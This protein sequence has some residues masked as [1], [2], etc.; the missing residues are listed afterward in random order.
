MAN[1]LQ[2]LVLK[3][4]GDS[5]GGQ[6]AVRDLANALSNN[7][8]KALQ[9][10]GSKTE[11]SS[12]KLSGFKKYLDDLKPSADNAGASFQSLHGT[13][14]EMWENPTAA[15]KGLAGAVGTDLSASLGVAGVAAGAALGVFTVLAAAA[16]EFA[17]R[18]AKVGANLNDMSEKTEIAV[19]VL[20]RWSN[21]A[22]V[23]GTDINTLANG[24][25]MMQ[26]QM[27]ESPDKFEKGLERINIDFEEFKRLSP[28][29]QLLAIA[30]GLRAFPLERT[31]AGVETLGRFAKDNIPSLLKMNEAMEM[32]KDLNP[33]TAEEAEQAEQFEMHLA[34]IKAH[35]EE[36]GT[37]LG[38]DV[39][40]SVDRFLGALEV[41]SHW[42]P[43]DWMKRL[44]LQASNPGGFAALSIPL[45]RSEAP[46]D[47]ALPKEGNGQVVGNTVEQT[48]KL[49][50]GAMKDRAKTAAEYAQALRNVMLAE[51]G[52]Q[53]ALSDLDGKVVEAIRFDLEHKAGIE[54][55]ARVYGV[56]RE[57]VKLVQ[58]Q[59]KAE[60]E[61]AK[62]AA[63]E[64]K[65][66]ADEHKKLLEQIRKIEH[67][68]NAASVTEL[69]KIGKVK[70]VVSKED[71]ANLEDELRFR[72]QYNDEIAQLVLTSTQFQIYQVEQ[73]VNDEKE[74]LK[75]RGGNWQAAYDEIE[76]IAKLHIQR[77]NA[78]VPTIGKAFADTLDGLPALIQQAFTGGGGLEGAMKAGVVLL[79][80]NLFGKDGVWAQTVTP[81]I[82]ARNA[83]ISAAILSGLAV[84]SGLVDPNSREGGALSGAMMGASAGAAIAPYLGPYG[85][86]AVGIGAGAGAIA[87]ALKV[88]ADEK[89]ARDQFN[90][91]K[92][93]LDD[94]FESVAT[95]Q[96]RI[97]AGG[98][99]WA[100]MVIAVR[101]AYVATGRTAAQAMF[102]LETATRH[103]RDDVE[104]LPD[105]LAKIN[106]ALK[107][108]QQ[109]TTDLNAA[110]SRYHFTLEELGPAFQKQELT[111]QALQLENS[112]RLLVGAGADAS[113]VIDRMGDDI[114]AF[115]KSALKTGT[116]VPR[117]MKPMLEQMAAAGKLLDENGN[118][119]TDLGD[120]GIKWSETMTQGFD[121]IVDA[122]E[123]VLVALGWVDLA[124]DHIPNQKTI[125]VLYDIPNPPSGAWL[126][127]QQGTGETSMAAGGFGRATGPRWFY[128]AGN[129]DFAFSGEG[130]TFAQM[131]TLQAR[132]SQPSTSTSFVGSAASFAA[133]ATQTPV[134]VQL[135]AE[136]NIHELDPATLQRV[137]REDVGP[138]FVGLVEDGLFVSRL[139][140]AL[141]R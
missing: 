75:A 68:N 37:N 20:S 70:E 69:E 138:A 4:G 13:L 34:S 18:A 53:G 129:E 94:M 90:T 89:N 130:K 113:L 83:E 103:T 17:E 114:N 8:A 67:E 21:A 87:G 22:K 100:K 125:K 57:Q 99:S 116:E 11:E 7:L 10:T 32:T 121:R 6:Q 133:G 81:Q 135:K 40:P 127:E 58:E 54:D 141:N 74:K 107:D 76:K 137:V 124:V 95:S 91:F 77:I 96:Q 31:A 73:W 88:P 44:L 79:G 120:S 36:I 64:E 63:E 27:A 48:D 104:K 101:E 82:K 78:Q 9:D 128:T 55:I 62:K 50:E 19:P 136:F 111:K 117:E 110:I 38:R 46:T 118:A 33:W 42:S 86:A 123:K 139:N 98:D 108:Q 5:S 134:I 1:A 105:D 71:R 72:R 102:D 43:S 60:T 52:Y 39:L 131:A 126:G 30:D 23:A 112:F 66:A 122:L 29:Q 61:Q 12:T 80:T 49:I 26:K 14:S 65:K 28:D 106:Q 140:Q 119:I 15:V 132:L 97:E 115:L 41:M 16:F 25:F 92:R 93:S 24:V 85:W 84:A 3:I 2:E 47:I 59:L 51:R 45:T 109:D 56:E 35:F